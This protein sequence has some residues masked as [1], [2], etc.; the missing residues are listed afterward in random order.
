MKMT[1]LITINGVKLIIYLSPAETYLIKVVILKVL[2]TGGTGLI[3][4]HLAKKLTERGDS[5][6]IASRNKSGEGYISWDP[7]DHNSL[8]IPG[9]TDAIIHL[10]GA[11]LFGQ[12]WT[13]D[14]KKE[15]IESRAEGTVTV[16]NAIRKYRGNLS[17]FISGSGC[18]YYG[19]RGET[20][21][22]EQ[23]DPGDNFMAKLYTEWE[24]VVWTYAEDT[25][26]G[27]G[28]AV[29]TVRTGMVLSRGG[30]ILKR[31]LN[32]F[33]FFKPF[34][35]GL[36]GYPGK[37]EQ[38][39]PWIHIEDEV[40]I[41]LHILDKKLEGPYNLT[42]PNP[43]TGRKF[44]KTLGSVLNRPALLPIPRFVLKRLYGEAAEIL[45]TSQRVIPK[46]IM[47]KNYKFK[48]PEIKPALED[49]LG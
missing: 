25:M 4:S 5:A 35:L 20:K 42:A 32:P 43:V 2:I 1:I 28:P 45:F 37:G 40:G 10:A 15:I 38:Y 31:M 13:E 33:S 36:G 39:M 18:G 9:G 16:L 6:V 30:G 21:I 11:P 41:L 23:N 22:S 44:S 27:T 46:A 48:F 24:K 7:Y 47:D 3:G 26:F 17:S 14:Y 34:K 19:D 29:S 49:V 8:K 12:K